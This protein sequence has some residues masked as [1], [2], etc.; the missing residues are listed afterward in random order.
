MFPV[1]SLNSRKWEFY[2][3][4]LIMARGVKKVPTKILLNRGSWRGKTRKNEPIYEV[5]ADVQPP[6][7]LNLKGKE[8]FKSISSRLIGQGVLTECDIAALSRYCF[9]CQKWPLMVN[10]PDIKMGDVSKVENMLL[11]LEVQFGLTPA[12]RPNIK[13]NVGNDDNSKSKPKTIKY[14]K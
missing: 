12:S 1:F 14:F 5:V 13:A 9:Y 8:L 4:G 3:K 7:F 10:N 2:Q 11:K 6:K